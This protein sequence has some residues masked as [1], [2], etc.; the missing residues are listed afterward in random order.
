MLQVLCAMVMVVLTL[1]PA[2]YLL[3]FGIQQGKAMTKAWWV[4]TMTA[5]ALEAVFTEA[6]A[7]ERMIIE[8]WCGM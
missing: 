5:F 7:G 8:R 1:F 6:G 2:L 4:S 3:L